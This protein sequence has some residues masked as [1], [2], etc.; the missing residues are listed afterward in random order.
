MRNTVR[1][2]VEEEQWRT[3]LCLFILKLLWIRETELGNF[4]FLEF[5]AK[6]NKKRNLKIDTQVDVTRVLCR[7][8]RKQQ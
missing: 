4:L 6:K 1:V 3:S 2:G 8:R 5:N 7:Q